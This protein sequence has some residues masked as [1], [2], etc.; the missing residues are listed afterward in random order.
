[1]SSILEK[2]IPQV[3]NSKDKIGLLPFKLKGKERKEN[4][5]G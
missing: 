3:S 1:M 4:G 2:Y 5:R